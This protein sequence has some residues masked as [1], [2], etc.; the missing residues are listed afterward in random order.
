LS[1]TAAAP[2]FMFFPF[3]FDSTVC[4]TD[5]AFRNLS[6]VKTGALFCTTVDFDVIQVEIPAVLITPAISARRTLC[7]IGTFIFIFVECSSITAVA[8]ERFIT[9]RAGSAAEASPTL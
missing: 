6:A 2:F 5:F 9:F 4:D 7:T 1:L 3:P 8:P